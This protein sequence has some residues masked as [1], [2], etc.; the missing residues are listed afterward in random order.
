MDGKHRSQIQIVLICCICLNETTQ[1]GTVVK[2]TCLRDGNTLN[3]QKSSWSSCRSSHW[4]CVKKQHLKGWTASPIL[5]ILFPRYGCAYMSVTRTKQEV[6]FL[7]N[8]FCLDGQSAFKKQQ[9]STFLIFITLI[10]FHDLDFV[11][12]TF[13]VAVI[14]FF[15]STSEH[16]L[17]SHSHPIWDVWNAVTRRS[18]TQFVP[19]TFRTDC[20]LSNWIDVLVNLR[21]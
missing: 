3:R 12:D 5:S 8:V 10:C 21:Q 17:K 15:K 14:F 2:R 9:Y 18:Q 11:Q 6:W 13:G 20:N 7:K 16:H 4:L 1:S 19:D